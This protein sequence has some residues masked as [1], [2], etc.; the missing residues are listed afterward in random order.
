MTRSAKAAI[1]APGHNVAAKRRLNRSLLYQGHAETLRQ[2][3]C[4]ASWLGVEV[5][6]VNPSFDIL[7]ALQ[8]RGGC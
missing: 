4:K 3:E 6:P 2:L 8:G 1:D 5:R 7:P